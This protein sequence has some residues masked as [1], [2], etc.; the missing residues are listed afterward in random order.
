MGS[1]HGGAKAKIEDN[2][3][4]S[5]PKVFFHEIDSCDQDVLFMTVEKH[6]CIIVYPRSV[7]EKRVARLTEDGYEDDE[8]ALKQIRSMQRQLKRVKLDKQG[9]I[10][11]PAELKERVGIDKEVELVGSVRR[12]EIWD[13]KELDKYDQQELP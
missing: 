5:L 8:K 10:Y 6:K 2:G 11:I 9:R 7:W 1:F 13:P 3:R 12:F 4:L